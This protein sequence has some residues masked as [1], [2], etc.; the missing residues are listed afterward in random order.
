[1]SNESSEYF[2]DSS[3]ALLKLN[4]STQTLME[5]QRH[6]GNL[7]FALAAP[8]P[9][10]FDTVQKT[11]IRDSLRALKAY[12]ITKT[13]DPTD[14]RVADIVGPLLDKH[15]ERLEELGEL[16]NKSQDFTDKIISSKTEGGPGLR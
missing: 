12:S 14:K 8:N 7:S 11:I 16:F 15:K 1:M 3:A 2:T 6:L 10:E 5:A 4:R 9:E 13:D